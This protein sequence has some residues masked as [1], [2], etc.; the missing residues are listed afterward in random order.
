MLRLRFN[1]GVE[2]SGSRPLRGG[3][4]P[5]KDNTPK[6]VETC[7]IVPTAFPRTLHARPFLNRVARGRH[8]LR[9]NQPVPLR[10]G[11]W[12]TTPNAEAKNLA[13]G[14]VFL[15]PLIARLRRTS[16]TRDNAPVGTNT[17]QRSARRTH[18]GKITPSSRRRLQHSR[19]RSFLPKITGA[20]SLQMSF[21][22]NSTAP[23]VGIPTH[24]ARPPA[25]PPSR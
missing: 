12:R 8:A 3:Y 1:P 4:W 5:R 21:R 22:G 13:P 9:H 17:N 7:S 18:P 16:W 6:A 11:K 15:E 25:Q 23:P 2:P 14:L 24:P 20:S 19:R 10:R